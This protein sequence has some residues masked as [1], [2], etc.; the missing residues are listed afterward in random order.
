MEAQS[1]VLQ[2][3]QAAAELAAEFYAARKALQG[4]ALLAVKIQSKLMACLARK[5]G[6]GPGKALALVKRAQ[7]FKHL[8]R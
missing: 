5:Q 2:Q 7:D 6:K 3:R 4:E 8:T 1:H